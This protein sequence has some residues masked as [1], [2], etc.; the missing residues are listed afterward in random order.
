MRAHG[1]HCSA[2]ACAINAALLLHTVLYVI[3]VGGVV[4][5]WVAQNVTFLRYGSI[6]A[7]GDSPCT[8][9]VFPRLGE[10]VGASLAMG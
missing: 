6:M 7:L 8:L 4:H 2:R 10:V 5:A 9:L 3:R 1:P